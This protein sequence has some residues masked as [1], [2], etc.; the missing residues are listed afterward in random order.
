VSA[1]NILLFIAFS[2][3][4]SDNYPRLGYMTFLDAIM[5]G[6]FIINALVLIYNVYLR[7]LEMR[8][9]EA[10]AESIDQVMD[11]VYP[12]IYL[13]AFGVIYYIFFMIPPPA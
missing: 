5:A 3:S 6:V 13:T 8:G 7:R 4:L 10:R 2:F 1:G 11:W 9:N 12:I